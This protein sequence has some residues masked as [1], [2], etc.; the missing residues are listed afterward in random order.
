MSIT[1]KDIKL[2]AL[3]KMFSANGTTIQTDSSNSE[4]LYAMPAA[5]N[6]GL[7]MLSTAGK[8]IIG[9]CT[10]VN[11]PVAPIYGSYDNHS[12]T[13][14]SYTVNAKGAKSYYFE[15]EGLV[16]IQI[17]VGETAVKTIS[18]DSKEAYTVFKG[19]IQND[20]RDNVTVRFVSGYPANVR[21]VALYGASY[22][23]DEDVDPY[24][25]YLHFNMDEIA[26][27][28]YQ[29]NEEQIYYEGDSEPR[30]IAA[31]DYYQEADKCLVIPRSMEGSYTIYYKK[32]PKEITQDTPDDYQLELDPEVAVLLP[33]YIASVLYMDDD[34]SIATSYRN[35]FE[36]GLARLTQRANVQSKE[37]F[38]SAS[39][40]C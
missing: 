39:G 17:I 35:F 6:E 25:E 23:S 1:W 36:T 10:I 24:T 29:L 11:R 2:T 5:A 12:F 26:D 8:F 7:Q 14:D 3:Q 30:Y 34:L 28:F 21:N 27:S 38:V 33:T 32:Y 15:V 19:N 22:H 31:S 37:E 40:W 9:K 13:A 20:S 4:Y 18:C 16:T